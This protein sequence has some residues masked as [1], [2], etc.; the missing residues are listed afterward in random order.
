MLSQGIQISNIMLWVDRDGLGCLESCFRAFESLPDDENGTW[1]L[2]DDVVISRRFRE[3]TEQHDS[4]IV[5]G[6]AWPMHKRNLK[7]VGEV[8]LED[9]WFSFPCIRIPNQTA[10]G[11]AKFYRETIMTEEQFR[12]WVEARRYDDTVFS[13]YLQ[14][15]G[16]RERIVNLVPN[17]VAHIDY[18][19]GGTVANKRDVDPGTEPYFDEPETLEKLIEWIGRRESDG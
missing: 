8:R 11:C 6:H 10:R 16:T 1:H 15:N 3:L 18:L 4:G 12:P 14:R 13:L 7:C 19:I 5:C 2:Q 17:L 9:M